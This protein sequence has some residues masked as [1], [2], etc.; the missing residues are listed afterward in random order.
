[1]P[2]LA[3]QRKHLTAN[4]CIKKSLSTVKLRCLY[5]T[6]GSKF[7]PKHSVDMC[8]VSSCPSESTQIDIYNVFTKRGQIAGAG[9]CGELHLYHSGTHMHMQVSC[10]LK[11]RSTMSS[12][13]SWILVTLV[14]RPEQI[15]M[16]TFSFEFAA[17]RNAFA[18]FHNAMSCCGDDCCSEWLA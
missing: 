3:H 15:V 18:N 2:A 17:I 8:T 7:T 12:G 4:M 6:H 1:M 16:T 10:I 13:R 14:S 11:M 9:S 5:A